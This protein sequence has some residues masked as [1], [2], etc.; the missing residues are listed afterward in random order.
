MNIQITS[1]PTNLSIQLGEGT[2]RILAKTL[3]RE[4]SILKDTTLKLDIGGG[5]LRN[6]FLPIA[7]IIL[8][9]HTNNA[10]LLQKLNMMLTPP[11]LAITEDLVQIA[12]DLDALEVR[13]NTLVPVTLQ[14][15]LMIDDANP[16]V[17]FTGYAP[18]GS[19][20]TDNVWAIM[21]ST[22]V[23]GVQKNEWV[24]GAQNLSS[25]WDARAELQYS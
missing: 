11:E 3:I 2:P 19:R 22:L 17:I 15:P 1:N 10:D 12:Q 24:N 9:A 14:E 13:L 4:V 8:P 7:D 25:A 18:A 21:K 23:D 5:A 20:G 6:I 16:H